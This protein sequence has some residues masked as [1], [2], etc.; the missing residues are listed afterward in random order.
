MTY[1]LY[2]FTRNQSL[3]ETFFSTEVLNSICLDMYS[4]KGTHSFCVFTSKNLVLKCDQNP[5]NKEIK[6]TFV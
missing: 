6:I 1:L 2:P 5:I 3:E 4:N